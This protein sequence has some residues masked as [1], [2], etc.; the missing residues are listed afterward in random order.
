MSAH[1]N[2]LVTSMGGCTTATSDGRPSKEDMKKSTV[3]PGWAPSWLRTLVCKVK[4]HDPKS[5]LM[6]WTGFWDFCDRCGVLIPS[7][8]W[9]SAE[10]EF[11]QALEGD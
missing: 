7:T 4:G 2:H 11:H 9:I 10:E 3:R 6:G 1:K 8:D 5:V